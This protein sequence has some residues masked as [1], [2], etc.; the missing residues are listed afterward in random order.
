MSVSLL[1]QYMHVHNLSQAKVATALGVSSATISQYLKG[2]Y[3]GDVAAIDKKVEQ[4]LA[5]AKDKA[6]DINSDFVATD[7]ARAIFDIC[8]M[9]HSMNDIN[10]VIGE[11]GLG[12][13]MA[14]KQYVASIDNVIL[15]EAE[16]TFSPKVLLNEL[17]GKLGVVAS[18]SNHDNIQAVVGKLK[19]TEKLIIIDEA[20]LL[21]YKC[22]EI[23]RRIHDLSGVGVVL[24]GMP[25][26]R[27]NLRGRR[28]EY[29]QLYSRIGFAYDLKNALPDG[30]IKRLV[31]HAIGT[32]A[33]NDELV[34]A[35]SGNARRLNKI[36]R[37]V[38]RIVKLNPDKHLSAKMIE[39]V[40]DMLIN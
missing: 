6:T 39:K 22:L 35:C 15:V 4:M 38:N 3:G 37:G 30:D 14:L 9:A 25:Q 26:L 16:P 19:G 34:K 40:T 8:G 29:K 17:C 11:A 2:I 32:D 13:T 33:F 24:A 31:Q 20:E 27:A 28:G 1:K 10:L 23:V 7:T 5:R 12:K 18:K 36:L 21:S